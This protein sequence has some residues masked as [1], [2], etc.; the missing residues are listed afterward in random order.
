MKSKEQCEEKHVGLA[1]LSSAWILV[2]MVFIGM[3]VV[4]TLGGS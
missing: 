2:L 3:N 1:D 4:L